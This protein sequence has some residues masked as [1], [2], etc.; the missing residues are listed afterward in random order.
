MHMHCIHTLRFICV[1]VLF[2]HEEDMWSI[3][4]IHLRSIVLFICG[5]HLIIVYYAHYMFMEN[6]LEKYSYHEPLFIIYLNQCLMN[7]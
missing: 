3:I 5:Y 2:W 6:L 7:L 1:E 4:F